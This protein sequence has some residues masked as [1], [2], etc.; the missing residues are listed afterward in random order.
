M[1]TLLALLMSLAILPACVVMVRAIMRLPP[2]TF[3]G[4]YPIDSGPGEPCWTEGIP[5]DD[6]FRYGRSHCVHDLLMEMDARADRG[7]FP[8]PK[9]YE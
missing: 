8:I 7:D 3:D 5:S 1:A 2:P 9:I 6:R 4:R